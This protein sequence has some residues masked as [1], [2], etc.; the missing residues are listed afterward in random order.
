MLAM[1]YHLLT[2]MF[3]HEIKKKQ[4]RT[5]TGALLF[6]IGDKFT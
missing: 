5:E 2:Y 4:E 1:P 3:V 6:F